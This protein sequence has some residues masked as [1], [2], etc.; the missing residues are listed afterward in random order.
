MSKKE[1]V[2]TLANEFDSQ[3]QAFFRLFD[4]WRWERLMEDMTDPD[5]E[6]TMSELLAEMLEV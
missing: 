2:I 3:N 1:I 4:D 6:K 5:N